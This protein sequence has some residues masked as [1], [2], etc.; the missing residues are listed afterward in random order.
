MHRGGLLNQTVRALFAVALLAAPRAHA[1]PV[2]TPTGRAPCPRL[3]RA[4]KADARARGLRAADK[5]VLT[6]ESFVILS[7]SAPAK[8]HKPIE[9]VM[10]SGTVDRST[11][12]VTSFNPILMD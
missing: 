7:I 10:A 4:V 8:T 1:T 3:V 5:V 9:R 2:A 11:G 6:G 12:K